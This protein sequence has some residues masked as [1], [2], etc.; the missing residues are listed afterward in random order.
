MK[1]LTGILLF[2]FF[3]MTIYWSIIFPVMIPTLIVAWVILWLQ[4]KFN[5]FN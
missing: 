4:A 5:C 1:H 2:V 3:A